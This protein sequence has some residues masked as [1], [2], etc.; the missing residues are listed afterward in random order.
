M[1]EIFEYLWYMPAETLIMSVL[2]GLGIATVLY[3]ILLII[4]AIAGWI[5]GWWSC[6]KM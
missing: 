3:I 2:A 4:A 5:S 1:K 6:R